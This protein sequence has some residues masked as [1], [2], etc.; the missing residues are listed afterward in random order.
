MMGIDFSFRYHTPDV[1][2]FET[3]PVSSE[4]FTPLFNCEAALLRQRELWKGFIREYHEGRETFQDWIAFQS[5]EDW[6]AFMKG[7]NNAANAPETGMFWGPSTP[8]APREALDWADAWI[9]VLESLNA[10]ELHLL[11]PL[12]IDPQTHQSSFDAAATIA[13]LR[14]LAQ[15]ARC[16]EH[17]NVEMTVEMA[18]R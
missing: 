13:V 7:Q 18:L 14:E 10:E 12:D 11:F 5:D 1:Q 8:F 2:A 15:Q 4:L 3:P 17:H 9:G 16:A 6:R